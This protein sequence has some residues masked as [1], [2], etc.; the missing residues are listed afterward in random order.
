LNI[1]T[2]E[3]V[4][5]ILLNRLAQIYLDELD[6]CVTLHSDANVDTLLD[7]EAILGLSLVHAVGLGPGSEFHDKGPVADLSD[8]FELR[9]KMPELGLSEAIP[10]VVVILI[11]RKDFDLDEVLIGT[12]EI[13]LLEQPPPIKLWIYFVARPFISLQERLGDL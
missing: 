9:D 2:V 13:E 12:K 4:L 11:P 1:H 10:L 8:L 3:K 6:V 7:G 5:I